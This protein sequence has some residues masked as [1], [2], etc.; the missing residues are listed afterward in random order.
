MS[1]KA[2]LLEIVDKIREDREQREKTPT[3]TDKELGA[4]AITLMAI[5]S[6]VEQAS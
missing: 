5:Q 4:D 1:E 6:A 2:P 3:N